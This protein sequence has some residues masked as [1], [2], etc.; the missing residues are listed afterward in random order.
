VAE[1]RL[2]ADLERLQERDRCVGPESISALS[3]ELRLPRGQVEGAALFYSFLSPAPRGDY[4]I[5]LS[6]C[7]AD[8]FQGQQERAQDLCHALSV[9]LGDTRADGRVS[10]GLTSCSGMC[11][12]GPSGL[13]NGQPLTRL[14]AARIRT[15]AEL[16]ERRAPLASW[17]DG[18]FAVTNNVRRK[19]LLLS[20][21][22]Q[23]GDALRELLAIGPQESLARIEQSGLRGRGGAGFRTGLKWKLCRE[24]PGEHV[25]VCNADEGEPGTFKD[26]VLLQSL[27]HLVIEG[28]TVCARIVH[29]RRGFLYLRGEYRYLVDGLEAV[30]AQRRARRLLGDHVL[31]CADFAFDVDIRLGAGAYVCGEESA[32][33]ESLEGKRGIPRI[34]PPF[35]VTFGY[36]GQPTVVNN[37]ETFAAATGILVHGADWFR[38]VGTDQSAGTKLLSVSGDCARPGVYE[39]PMGVALDD[40]LAAS[41]AREPQAVQISGP[42]GVCV[43]PREFSRRIAYEDLPAGGAVMAIGPDR[44]LLEVVANHARFFAHESCGFCTPCRVGTQL[45]HQFVTKLRQGTASAKDLINLEGVAQL[46]KTASHCGLGQTAGHAMLDTMSRFPE[47]YQLRRSAA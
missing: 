6:D 46:M 42:A 40:V 28:M 1:P 44:D 15:V 10:V 25:V 45:Q 11:D 43:A 16:I 38:S 34:R 3:R 35:P 47:L 18:L 14:T 17:P 22:P 9:P 27:A 26:R 37:V 31:D 4:H 33:I 8:H 12:Q 2:L 19:D 20:A 30:L 21:L 24:A 32:L 5:L 29:A 39:F 7:L 41:G 36:Q 13:V 23:P